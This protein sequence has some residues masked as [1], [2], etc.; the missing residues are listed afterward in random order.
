MTDNEDSLL[1]QQ[2]APEP[3]TNRRKM[4]IAFIAIIFL[5]LLALLVNGAYRYWLATMR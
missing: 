4:K 5:A 3:K 1:A 2:V